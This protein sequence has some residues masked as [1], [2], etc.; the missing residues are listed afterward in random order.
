M[1]DASM[2]LESDKIATQE[3]AAKVLHAELRSSTTG[4]PQVG[5][6]AAALQVAA[7]INEYAGLIDGHFRPVVPSKDITFPEPEH[8]VS[9]ATE[10]VPTAGGE[11]HSK[12]D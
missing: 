4:E 9:A 6:V 11:L 10:N 5:G 1:Q 2:D 3:D 8:A 12:V 7:N